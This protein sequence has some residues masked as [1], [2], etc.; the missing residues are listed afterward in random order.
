MVNRLIG[1]FVLVMTVA[2]AAPASGQSR[3]SGE[4]LERAVSLS[5]PAVATN[6]R[7]HTSGNQPLRTFQQSPPTKSSRKRHVL[8]G[9][10][11]GA[12]AGVVAAA[13]H[14]GGFTGAC[15][16]AS[17]IY[18]FSGAGVGALV[19]ALM[20]APNVSPV[21]LRTPSP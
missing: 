15:M 6:G 13:I 19:G 5:T 7:D 3:I 18:F 20:P 14:C 11:A 10:A 17:P 2:I 12:A 1:G 9:A 8:L 16:E 4:S 21:T